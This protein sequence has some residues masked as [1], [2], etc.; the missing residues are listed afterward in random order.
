MTQFEQAIKLDMLTMIEEGKMVAVEITS[1]YYP[2][3]YIIDTEDK[4][5]N[6]PYI[7][8]DEEGCYVGMGMCTTEEYLDHYSEAKAENVKIWES[9]EDDE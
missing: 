2:T 6:Y 9:E 1:S 8:Y 7:V 5:G 4:Y 3:F